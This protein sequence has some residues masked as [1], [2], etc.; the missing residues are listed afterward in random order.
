MKNPHKSNKNHL[1]KHVLLLKMADLE[2]TRL[3]LLV[4]GLSRGTAEG[5]CYAQ[6]QFECNRCSFR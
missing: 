5:Q 4:G 1:E 3:S 6:A 2:E